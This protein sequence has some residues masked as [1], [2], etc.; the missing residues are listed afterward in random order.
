MIFRT[1]LQNSNKEL[2]Y[3]RFGWIFV[4][5]RYC[6]MKKNCFVVLPLR[7]KFG[8]KICIN[9]QRKGQ[10]ILTREL[11]SLETIHIYYLLKQITL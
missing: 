8:S 5:Q 10:I 7:V 3:S 9:N 1:P 11:V 4:F 2:F 6:A